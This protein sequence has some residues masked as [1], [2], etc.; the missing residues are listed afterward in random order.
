M[1]IVLFHQTLTWIG[2]HILSK[3]VPVVVC[4]IKIKNREKGSSWVIMVKRIVF[5][6]VAKESATERIL[7]LK[8]ALLGRKKFRPRSFKNHLI[9]DPLSKQDGPGSI[10]ENVMNV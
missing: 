2:L 4:L 3:L 6:K 10:L 5:N 1:G 8:L 9:G 7:Y